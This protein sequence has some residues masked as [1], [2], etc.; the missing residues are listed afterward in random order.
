M[1]VVELVDASEAEPCPVKGVIN[2]D[3]R[4][5]SGIA[6][7]TFMRQVTL[8]VYAQGTSTNRAV[9]ED[10]RGRPRGLLRTEADRAESL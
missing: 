9:S 2:L 8:A 1:T 7:A 3:E 5:A 4:W 10:T 6:L